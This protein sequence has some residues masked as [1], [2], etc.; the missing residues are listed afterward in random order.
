[1][2]GVALD[3]ACRRRLHLYLTRIDTARGAAGEGDCLP[4]EAIACSRR[5]IFQRVMLWFTLCFSHDF[6]SL[7]APTQHRKKAQRLL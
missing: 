6:P 5:D 3:A 1:M 4:V 7:S 2:G